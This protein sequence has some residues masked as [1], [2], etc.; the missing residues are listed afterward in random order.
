[1]ANQVDRVPQLLRARFE[2]PRCDAFAHQAWSVLARAPQ[3][4]PFFDTIDES[5]LVHDGDDDG[6]IQG[7]TWRA[8]QCQSCNNWSVWRGPA[9][10]YPRSSG[11]PAPADNMPS[12]VR[13]AYEE[14][15][16]VWSTSR[17]AGAALARAALELLLRSDPAADRN[18]DLFKLIGD[19]I[20]G[21]PA[22][23]ARLLD[24]IRYAGNASLHIRSEVD[25]VMVLVLDPRNDEIGEVL[26]STINMVVEERITRPAQA[27]ALVGSL[28]EGV[29]EAMAKRDASP[30]AP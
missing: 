1:M 4:N 26:F 7:D 14:A 30:P 25:G 8:S 11:L 15:R 27:S 23:P 3:K 29:R 13:E 17:R 5:A 19:A 9:L 18:A 24:V 2:C 6:G 10:V 16:A 22:G 21:L 12:E 28:P 20:A